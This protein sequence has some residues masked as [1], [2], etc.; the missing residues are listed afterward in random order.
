MRPGSSAY[1]TSNFAGRGGPCSRHNDHYWL[2][3]N[4]VGVGPGAASHRD[5]WRGTNLKPVDAWAAAVAAG[6]TPIGDAETL[7][8]FD[9]LAEAVWLG[10]R[11]RAGV[12]FAAAAERV[13][14][15]DPTT[16]FHDAI[17]QA[18]SDG[19]LAQSGDRLVLTPAGR[20]Y[21]DEVSGAFLAAGAG[22]RRRSFAAPATLPA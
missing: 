14:V 11:R 9:R 7:S 18:T 3:G 22:L 1:E 13:G 8:R 4:Y 6:Q 5:G 16:A 17:E 15:D 12:P 20:P 2:Q 21:A 10:L 19:T